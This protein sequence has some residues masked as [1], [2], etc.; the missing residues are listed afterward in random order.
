MQRLAA[1]R[2]STLEVKLVYLKHK[3][4][5]ARAKGRGADAAE[6]DLYDS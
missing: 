1:G 4:A 6:L 3:F 2:A 5:T